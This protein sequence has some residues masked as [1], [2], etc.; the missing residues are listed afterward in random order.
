MTFYAWPVGALAVWCFTLMI[1]ATVADDLALSPILTT[2]GIVALLLC[3]IYL[4]HRGQYRL[5]LLP[6]FLVLRAGFS[7]QRWKWSELDGIRLDY[8]R[9]NVPI[10]S[11]Q[12]KSAGRIY[13]RG[14]WNV[15]EIHLHTAVRLAK[16]QWGRGSPK[17][18]SI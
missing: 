6:G 17:S 18:P 14:P 1:Y 11:F 4:V 5:L 2:W 10:I 7:E 9:L 16:A 12:T 8:S 3:L 15:D 13:V